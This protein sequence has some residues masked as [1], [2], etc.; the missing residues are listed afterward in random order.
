MTIAILKN[1][2]YYSMKDDGFRKST[3]HGPYLAHDE[4]IF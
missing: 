4:V 2:I 3:S 1:S